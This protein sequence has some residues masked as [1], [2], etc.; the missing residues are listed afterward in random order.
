MYTIE[1]EIHPSIGE[2]VI[3]T[4]TCSTRQEFDKTIEL[5]RNCGHKLLGYKRTFQEGK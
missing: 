3:Q 1:I 2:A 4:I 5:I